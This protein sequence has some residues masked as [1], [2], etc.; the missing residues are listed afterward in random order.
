MEIHSVETALER[1][2][3]DGYEQVLL[4]P[5]LLIP[6]EEADRLASSVQRS[7]GKLK[8]AMGK[9]L[10]NEEADMDVLIPIL[11]EAYPVSSDTVLLLMGHGTDHGANRLYERFNQKMR[12][13]AGCVMRIC[14]MEGTP[15][16]A[17][18]VE[19]LSAL[20]QR[21]VTL[22]PLLFVA[23]EHVKND[24]AGEKPDSL[25]SIL[26]ASGFTATPVLQGLGQLEA[27]RRLFVER[28]KALLPIIPTALSMD[29][30]GTF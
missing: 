30:N 8:I 28:A 21:K 17:D 4:Q 5:T 13:D 9:P 26:K 23:G 18:A 2:A 16:F 11:K 24:M 14:T 15:T 3:A 10:L 29:C 7:A 20:P 12:Q 25:C 6:G 22:A 27:I 1:I 19:E